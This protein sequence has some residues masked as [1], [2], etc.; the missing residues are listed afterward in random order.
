LPSSRQIQRQQ[1][2]CVAGRD[3]YDVPTI[4]KLSILEFHS[5]VAKRRVNCQS[6]PTSVKTMPDDVQHASNEDCVYLMFFDP[7][8][9]RVVFAGSVVP[10]EGVKPDD[11]D[12]DVGPV[13]A[14]TVRR[15]AFRKPKR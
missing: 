8:L 4:R 12:A 13:E 10:R 9:G 5:R 7:K 3:E 15:E 2:K 14:S 1:D 11:K 6:V